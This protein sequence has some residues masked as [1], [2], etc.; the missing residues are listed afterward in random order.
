MVYWVHFAKVAAGLAGVLLV[1]TLSHEAS[2]DVGNPAAKMQLL[3]QERAVRHKHM[4][5][6]PTYQE[7]EAVRTLISMKPRPKTFTEAD[8]KYL[9]GFLDK[10][11]CM[12]GKQ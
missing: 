4:L 6:R 11:G 5:V 2:A 7:R 8:M 1:F 10:A 12:G 9:K 3:Q